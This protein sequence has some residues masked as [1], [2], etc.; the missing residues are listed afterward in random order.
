MSIPSV[1]L[2]GV[3]ASNTA[4][5]TAATTSTNGAAGLIGS[6]FMSLLLAQLK[7]QNPMEPMQD[8]DMM[9]QMVQLNSLQELQALRSSME[10]MTKASLSS[11]AA[12]LIGKTVKANLGDDKILQGVVDSISI[13][14]GDYIAH[15]G[16]ES[17][18]VALISE[19]SGGPVK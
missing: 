5:A 3:V 15:I 2:S 11:Y 13:E 18:S 7:N 4:A 9:N 10:V 6:Q 8:K 14:K 16:N 17:V 19:V 1:N 12:N